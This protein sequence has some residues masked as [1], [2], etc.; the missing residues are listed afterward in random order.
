[1][2]N[3]FLYYL[4]NNKNTY[5]IFFLLVVF[6]CVLKLPSLFTSDIQPWDEGMY[7]TRVLSININGDFL[8]QSRH[9]V[10][11]FYSGS[12]PPLL[13]WIGYFFCSVFGFNSIALKIIP[14]IF[15]LLC[16]W[17]LILIGRKISDNA[18]G[19]FSALIF[20]SNIIFNVFSKRFQFDIPYTF[21]IL[22]SFYF[23]FVYVENHKLVYNI[24]GGM[25]FGLC[26][27]I[28]ILVGFYIPAI[29][30]IFYLFRR[31]KIQYTLF[32]LFVFSLTGILI[33]LPW[34]IYMIMHYGK[35]FINYF[36]FFHIYE[37]AFFGVEQNTK[38]SGYL[39]HINYLLSI[40]PYSII[41]F[42][43]SAKDI[44]NFRK[45]DSNK[46]FL[47][48]WFITG[49]LILT[50]FK[51]KLEV[52]VLLILTPGAL[53][54]ADYIKDLNKISKKEKSIFSIM[55]FLNIFWYGTFIFRNNAKYNIFEFSN[56]AVFGLII[57]LFLVVFYFTSGYFDKKNNI[58]LFYYIFIILFFIS[59]NIY[60]FFNVPNWE[61]TYE[62]TSIKN[63]I[64]KNGRK[65]I[66]Y[67]STN[68]RANPQFSFYFKGLDLN[69]KND[70]NKYELLDTK[71][72][73]EQI[74]NRIIN[75]KKGE[76][77]I[78][79]EGDNINRSNY[80]ESKYF[81]PDNIK[82]IKKTSGY[83]LYNY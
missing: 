6:L 8:D 63:E 29:I 66:L 52:Y 18:T 72:G 37:R 49:L 79:V 73:I 77:S 75:L 53:L 35:E 41:V 59:L 5:K 14:F 42:I 3:N 36:F 80:I 69:W 24:L 54:I 33:S 47:L 50:F 16:L 22:L 19:I 23:F 27:M 60:Y 61:N 25:V 56:F 44:F 30:L 48:I 38:G 34:H 45:I 10:G 81:I 40:I 64:E 21:L 28:K 31:N 76:Y 32:D 13:I 68:Y 58:A 70:E 83:E 78:I 20:S 39:Y 1:M 46:L 65:N 71:N 51:T 4:N 2:T 55:I 57:M 11:Q 82:L 12:H 67:I 9:S 62:L 7:A 43:S 17:M 26:L 74:K 15:S